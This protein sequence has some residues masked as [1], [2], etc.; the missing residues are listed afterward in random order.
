MARAVEYTNCITAE[1]KDTH[2]ACP[3]YDTKQSDGEA[4]VML[5]FWE[6]LSMVLFLRRIELFNIQTIH[7]C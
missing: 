2:N 7:L 4:S 1:R 3:C 5:E 6:M